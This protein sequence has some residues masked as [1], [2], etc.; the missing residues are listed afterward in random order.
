LG[1][2]SAFAQLRCRSRAVQVAMRRDEP[3]PSTGLVQ[4]LSWVLVGIAL[5]AAALVVVI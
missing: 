5:A 2:R 4:A 3:L 1:A